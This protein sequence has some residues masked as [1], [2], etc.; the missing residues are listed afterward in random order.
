HLFNR[1]TFS[2]NDTQRAASD[3]DWT[4]PEVSDSISLSLSHNSWKPV[5][6]SSC[7]TGYDLLHPLPNSHAYIDDPKLDSLI[8]HAKPK[9]FVEPSGLDMQ[10]SSVLITHEGIYGWAREY[11]PGYSDRVVNYGHA[12]PILGVQMARSA[13]YSKILMIWWV[14]GSG[15]YGQRDVPSGFSPLTVD[16]NMAIYQYN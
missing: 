9:I 16:G 15:W 8:G 4:N 13:G 2:L 6:S 3:L 5:H 11:L 7:S 14:N 12:S 10:D 1:R